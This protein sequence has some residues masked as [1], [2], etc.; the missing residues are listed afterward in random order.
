MQ[1]DDIF[2][3]VVETIASTIKLDKVEAAAIS[4]ETVIKT[5]LN[6]DSLDEVEVLMNIEKDFNI[7]IPDNEAESLKTVGD[8][9]KLI[10][11]KTAGHTYHGT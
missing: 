5:D 6:M 9:I 7:M 10:E 4:E 8:Y 11:L 2:K 1:H 3:R